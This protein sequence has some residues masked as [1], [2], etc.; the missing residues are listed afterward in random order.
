MIIK[1]ASLMML[2]SFIINF[3]YYYIQM[4]ST[5]YA[6]KLFGFMPLFSYYYLVLG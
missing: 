5:H 2:L 4:I 6:H 3:I 1:Y